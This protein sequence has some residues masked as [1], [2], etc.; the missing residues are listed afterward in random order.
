MDNVTVYSNFKL[1]QSSNNSK[2]DSPLKKHTFENTAF[3]IEELTDTDTENIVIS[4]NKLSKEEKLMLDENF[5]ME[6]EVSN[7]NITDSAEL[8]S[9]NDTVDSFSA[10]TDVIEDLCDG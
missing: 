9:S 2:K 6:V 10:N 4:S 5:V 8:F 7:K 1:E 3:D